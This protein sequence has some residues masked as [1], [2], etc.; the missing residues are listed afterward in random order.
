M[1]SIIHFKMSNFEKASNEFGITEVLCIQ[2]LLIFLGKPFQAY[3]GYMAGS[4]LRKSYTRG[5][6]PLNLV[7]TAYGTRHKMVQMAQQN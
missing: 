1:L 4:L 3:S 6:C 5:E 2:V 7:N